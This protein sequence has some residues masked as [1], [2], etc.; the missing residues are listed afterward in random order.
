MFSE[1]KSIFASDGTFGCI[2][3]TTHAQTDV[4][5][6]VE[7]FFF[8]TKSLI[9]IW[10]EGQNGNAADFARQQMRRRHVVQ[11]DSECEML[12]FV[13]TQTQEDPPE[14]LDKTLP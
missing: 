11:R 3:G 8:F 12:T 2:L 5:K 6:N 10:G 14:R 4:A 7:C 1:K 13:P 9:Q